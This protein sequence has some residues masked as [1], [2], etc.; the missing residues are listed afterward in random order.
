MRTVILGKRPEELERWIAHRQAR[1]ADTHDEVWEG[2]YHTAPAAN[3]RHN[4]LQLT[5]GALLLDRSRE[6]GLTA[7]AE[8]NLGTA[9]D[10]RI[11]DLGVL[12]EFQPTDRSPTALLVVEIMSPYDE[13]WMKFDF[14]FAHGVEEVVIIDPDRHTVS[15][16][17]RGTGAYHPVEHSRVLDLPV[18]DVVSQI[19]WPPS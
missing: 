19:S 17:G 7:L 10:Y 3:T 6:L 15:W 9:D 1:G 18:A 13:S 12:R 16:F 8:F 11:P 2:V 14:Y 4:W 5:L